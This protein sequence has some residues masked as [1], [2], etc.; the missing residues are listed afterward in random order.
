MKKVSK[1][2]VRVLND[3][4]RKELQLELSKG[5]V[6]KNHTNGYVFLRFISKEQIT[7]NAG[8]R[9]GKRAYKFSNPEYWVVLPFWE[10]LKIKA[11]YYLSLKQF[12][13]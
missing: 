6:L 9:R 10:G 13:K 2:T 11:M 1:R 4:K 8:K 12:I 7:I 3:I 5:K